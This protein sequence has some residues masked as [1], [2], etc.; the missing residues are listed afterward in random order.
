[1]IIKNRVE[2]TIIANGLYISFVLHMGRELTQSNLPSDI[3]LP[4]ILLNIYIP[5][6]LHLLVS[7]S[8][9]IVLGHYMMLK[10]NRFHWK[11]NMYLR[12]L[13]WI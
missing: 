9:N 11:S 4:R 2:K 8:V 12:V 7:C 3:Q 6:I 5:N 10:M 1:M 13:C